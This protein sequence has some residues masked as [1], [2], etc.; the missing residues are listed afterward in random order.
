MTASI[1][2]DSAEALQFLISTRR[3]QLEHLSLDGGAKM[4]VTLN[5]NAGSVVATAGQQINVG[6]LLDITASNNPAYVVVS[7][8]DRNEY[9]ASSTGETGTLSGNGHVAGF[10]DTVGGDSDTVGIVFTYN[11]VTGQYANATYGSLSSLVYTASTNTNDNTSISIFTANNSSVATTFANN[12]YD[13]QLLSTSGYGD[14]TSYVGS[15]AVVTQPSFAGPAPSQATPGSIEAA[16]MSFVG[17]TWNDEGCWVL[18]SNISTEAG[19]SL[20]ITST[21]LGVPGV[22]NGE[23]IVAYDGPAGQTGNWESQI[24]AGEMVAF[25]TTS[26]GGH[27]TTVV[28]GSGSSAMVVDNAVMGNNSANDGSSADIVIAAPHAASQEWAQAA[29]GTVVVY[30]L[31]CPNITTTTAS[32]AVATGKTEALSP[33]FTAANPLASQAITEYQFYDT[34]TSG[35]TGSFLVGNTD[36]VA[37]SAAGAVTVGASAL[38]SVDFLAGNSSGTDTVEVRAYNGSYWG[39]W[40]SMTVDVTGA[41]APSQTTT[42]SASTQN[43]A[44]TLNG[45]APTVTAQTAAQTW[46]LGQAVDFALAANTFTDPQAEAMTYTATLTSGAALPSWLAFNAATR[47]FTGTVP[48][49]AAGLSVKVTATDTSGLSASETFAVAT[50]APAPPTVTAQTAT[51]TWKLGQA[52]DFTLAANTFADPQA[53]AMTYTATLASGAALPSWLNFNAATETFI[54]TA[55]TGTAGLSVKVTATDAGG[56]A[57]SE[58]F[59]VLASA[60]APPIITAQTANQFLEI[61]QAVDLTLAAN[62]FTDPQGES[63][64]YTAT[65]LSGAALPSWLN[66]NAATETFT[67]AVSIGALNSAIKVTATDTSGLSKYEQINFYLSAPAAPTITAH[68]AN[69]IV[70]EGQSINFSLAANTFTDP[71]GEN[72]SYTAKLT[73]GA[74]L[75]SWLQ[76]NAVTEAFTGTAPTSTSGL[77]IVVA[78]T[79]A[80]GAV[81]SETF[82]VSIVA[83]AGKLA[84]AISSVSPGS[85]SATASIIAAAT[86]TTNTLATPAH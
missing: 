57:A 84:S 73:T 81:G 5:T 7:L 38:S 64:T 30:E 29:A 3:R 42:Q 69:Q 31:D 10:S 18:A 58:T 70:T 51:Q 83:A 35:A 76:F 24:T 50:P 49:G 47:T 1:L 13:L 33:L 19:A 65:L 23:W 79:D 43:A 2:S 14:Y 41:A 66:F 63:L 25:E 82:S 72:M 48:S 36:D 55:P 67:G 56:A 77:S 86:S 68:T 21:E 9:T 11:A 53:E 22:A 44:Q 16:A 28:S 46:K 27:I 6:S 34:G 26:G 32:S 12:P 20:P 61:G 17:K 59:S 80:G 52:V 78:A 62:T 8:L 4:S 54:G 60:P 15:V 75:P 45:A 74:A 85:S 39:D 40:K 37:T 71:Q